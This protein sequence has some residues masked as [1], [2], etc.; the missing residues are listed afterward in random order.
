MESSFTMKASDVT[1]FE[2]LDAP[3]IYDAVHKAIETKEG[4]LVE[5]HALGKNNTGDEVAR[6]KITWSFKSK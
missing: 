3:A 6:F 4:Q 1:T 5:T 2:C